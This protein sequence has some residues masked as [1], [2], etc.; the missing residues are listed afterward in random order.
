MTTV[1]VLTRADLAPPPNQSAL[2]EL[3]ELRYASADDL[4]DR[5][6]GAQVLFVW[7]FFSPALRQAWS[8][9][10]ELDWVHVAAAGVD[11][12]LF[13]ELRGSAVTVTN[14]SGV[15]DGPIAEYVAAQVLAYAKQ[16]H[17]SAELQ[18]ERRW[19]HRETA[20]VAGRTA[21]VVGTGGI[22]RATARLLRA[23][24]KRM[25]TRS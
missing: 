13:D 7:D 16:L 2:A 20:R 14:A 5:I 21:L 25:P 1:V 4:G 24:R 22:G 6:G 10:D 11:A 19:E 9:A 18:R 3:V 8:Q 15:F 23:L 17:Y 12:V